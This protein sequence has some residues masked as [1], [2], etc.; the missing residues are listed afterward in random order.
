MKW[1]RGVLHAHA[2]HGKLS[3][4]K[5]KRYREDITIGVRHYDAKRHGFPIDIVAADPLPAEWGLLLGD[6]ATNLRAA[7]DHSAWAIVHRGN[8]GKDELPLRKGEAS[9]I[10][11]PIVTTSA[12]QFN[13]DIKAK[14]IGAKRSDIALV[15]KM[16][17]YFGK[18]NADRHA[19]AILN[20]LCT[21]DKHRAVQPVH[22]A[23]TAARYSILDQWDCEPTTDKRLPRP[24]PAVVKPG[25]E[26][27]VVRVRKTGPHPR[28]DIDTRLAAAP[29]VTERSPI[30][31]WLNK[32]VVLIRT[33]LSHL[34][35]PPDELVQLGDPKLFFG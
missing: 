28:I 6:I 19:L 9:A 13:G 20:D 18:G 32:S 7:L 34:A 4:Y 27:G 26:L 5:A 15:R 16:Q 33:F 30:D 23:I 12:A 3:A 2:L 8:G 1:G 10:Y 14:L 29:G 25:V 17:P 21:A 35:P 31:E 24:R 22:M 11:F